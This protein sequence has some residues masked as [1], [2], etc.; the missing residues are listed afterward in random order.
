[1]AGRLLGSEKDTPMLA[2][3]RNKPHQYGSVGEMLTD[4]GEQIYKLPYK[5]W[6]WNQAIKYKHHNTLADS[7]MGS[8][9]NWANIAKFS[10][11]KP[12]G[13]GGVGP[14]KES[15]VIRMLEE[16]TPQQAV[17][18]LTE[19]FNA[20]K[21]V[22]IMQEAVPTA[23]TYLRSMSMRAQVELAYMG[24][25]PA[26]NAKAMAGLREMIA[27][28][29]SREAEIKAGAESVKA[30]II[31]HN[32]LLDSLGRLVD[33]QSAHGELA[34]MI[35]HPS[36]AMSGIEAGGMRI[37]ESYM[38]TSSIGV[39]KRL[40]EIG[41]ELDKSNTSP[42]RAQ[43]LISR[44]VDALSDVFYRD[45]D[46]EVM[47][48]ETS[49]RAFMSESELAATPRRMQFDDPKDSA[50]YALGAWARSKAMK[51]TEPAVLDD[52]NLMRMVGG[53]GNIPAGVRVEAKQHRPVRRGHAPRG[54]NLP[55]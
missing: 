43:L 45:M 29:S 53:A 38:A 44:V 11:E 3:L 10:E 5:A 12:Y 40:A 35:E 2:A 4:K 31:T 28:I 6:I 24:T 23:M 36:S 47:A 33:L 48:R 50:A 55:A 46:I 32:Q 1:M 8:W 41:I 14:K 22:R 54:Q 13:E 26:S 25:R 18:A 27:D 15:Y 17:D 49:E 39:A 37:P 52:Y 42:A 20:P 21:A 9:T 51:S 16:A 19:I 34:A 7:I 30:G